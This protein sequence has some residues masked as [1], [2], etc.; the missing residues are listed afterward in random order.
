MRRPVSREQGSDCSQISS[1]HPCVTSAERRP[2][3]AYTHCQNY[4]SISNHR[5]NNSRYYWYQPHSL[6]GSAVVACSTA[7]LKN[8]NLGFPLL[9]SRST[10]HKTPS[11]SIMAPHAQNFALVERDT[12]NEWYGRGVNLAIISI[13]MSAMATILVITRLISRFDFNR[14]KIKGIGTDDVA[15]V[16]SLVSSGF[17]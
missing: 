13:T 2:V 5:I 9:Q 16:G 3:L 7:I 4:Q 15:I 10:T 8:L 14:K 1:Q 11:I 17:L 6:F 12:S